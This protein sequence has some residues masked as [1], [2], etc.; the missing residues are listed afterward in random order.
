[1]GDTDAVNLFGVCKA[2]QFVL[3]C[4]ISLSS[5]P[6]LGATN[7]THS[8]LL[9]LLALLG[10]LIVG[11]LSCSLFG[12]GCKPCADCLQDRIPYMDLCISQ[13]FLQVSHTLVELCHICGLLGIS[14]SPPQLFSKVHH[15]G[16]LSHAA[17]LYLTIGATNQGTSE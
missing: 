4:C 3:D 17:T 14:L 5:C 1:M 7:S 6:W 11:K 9:Q 12:T 16:C 10:V 15:C 8:Y 2:D 13:L